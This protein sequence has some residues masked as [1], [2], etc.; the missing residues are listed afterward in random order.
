V[1]ASGTIVLPP[2]AVLPA[3]ATWTVQILDISLAETPAPVIGEVTADIADPSATEIPFEVSYD[4]AL[5]DDA[6]T[7]AL[8]A[9]IHDATSALLFTNDTV[10]P[11][12]TGGAP[13]IGVTIDVVPAPE[14]LAESSLLAMES[15]TP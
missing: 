8:R 5:I 9:S 15:T 11:V 13:T 3:D 6:A 10:T 2:G 14:P 12:I 1:A 7:Y 4:P